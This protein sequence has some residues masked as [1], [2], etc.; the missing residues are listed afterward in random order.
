MTSDKPRR[1][2]W[3]RFLPL[4]VLGT[5]IGIAFSLGLDD[6]L[7][8][9]T[10]RDNRE[11]LADFVGNHAIAAGATYIAV[12][13]VVVAVSLPGATFLTLA[14]AFMFGAFLGTALTLVGA[15]AGATVI[16]LVAKSALGNALRERAGPGLKRMEEGF[17]DNA[18]NYLLVLRLI[19]LFPFWLVNLVPAFLGVPLRTY[20]IG[21][22]I[23]IIPGTFVYCLAG[24]GLSEIFE[25]GEDFSAAN[26]LTP[27]MIAALVGL[28][29][30]ALLPV[31]HKRY[32]ARATS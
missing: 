32:R 24:A 6:Y 9:E 21:T 1:P 2:A 31:I 3:R 5:A 26:I 15:T 7:S 29:V 27:T 13:T 28:A 20:V 16:F 25:S 12:Y 11:R 8:F 4:A 18:F 10:L 30:L 22:F 19:P 23:G 14:G 17:R